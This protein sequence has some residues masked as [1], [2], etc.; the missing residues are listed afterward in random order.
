MGWR[1]HVL[2]LLARGVRAED[3]SALRAE[4]VIRVLDR[5]A[6]DAD[7]DARLDASEALEVEREFLSLYGAESEADS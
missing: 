6:G 3:G 4:I 7:L 1:D 2:R 5:I